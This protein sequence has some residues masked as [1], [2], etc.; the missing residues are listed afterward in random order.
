ML[1]NLINVAAIA[2]GSLL[3]LLFGNPLR[4][5]YRDACMK[6]G[7]L[8]L[9]LLGIQMGLETENMILVLVSLALGSLLGELADLHGH[10]ESFGQRV[11]R[12]I[13]QK[14]GSFSQGFVYATLLFCIGPM[15]IVGSIQSGLTGDHSV[16]MTKAV[17]DGIF[18]FVLTITMGIGVMA[19]ALATG[20]YQGIF[21]LAAG[22]ADRYMT[23]AMVTELTAA[24]GLLILAIGLNLLEIKKFKTANMLPA[25]LFAVVLAAVWR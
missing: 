14:G 19:S 11:E 20:V 22:L 7:G 17:L 24:G 23:E 2:G 16:L 4:E 12:C 21:V 1:G 5:E 18:A 15:S 25:L 8:V 6:A 10:M 9:L 3:G 13:G